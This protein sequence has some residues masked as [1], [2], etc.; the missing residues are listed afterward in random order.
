[1]NGPTTQLVEESRER[2][3]S[4]LAPRERLV[5]FAIGGSFLVAAVALL[6]S[7]GPAD[8]SAFVVTVVALAAASRVAFEVG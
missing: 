1:M 6:T 3:V 2:E 7:S 5:E 4:R 8:W